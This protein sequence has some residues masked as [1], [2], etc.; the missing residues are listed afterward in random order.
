MKK[1]LGSQVSVRH[2]AALGNALFFLWFFYNGVDSGFA[3]TRIEIAGWLGMFTLLAWSMVALAT[4]T[5]VLMGAGILGNVLGLI[6]VLYS[7]LTWG[8]GTNMIQVLAHFGILALLM[9]NIA[10][11]LA[12]RRGEAVARP[13]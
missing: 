2:I 13:G 11:L 3:G 4:L 7:T 6:G 12:A 9:L 10:L 1:N 8:L 5:P